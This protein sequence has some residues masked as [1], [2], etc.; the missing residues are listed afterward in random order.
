MPAAQ[1]EVASLCC[2]LFVLTFFVHLLVVLAC[3]NG[4]ARGVPRAFLSTSCGFCAEQGRGRHAGAFRLG[5]SWRLGQRKTS[6]MAPYTASTGELRS[7][8]DIL[9]DGA[10]GAA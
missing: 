3:T 4:M 9:P 1:R 8:W 10:G 5:K 2:A 7:R 6:G